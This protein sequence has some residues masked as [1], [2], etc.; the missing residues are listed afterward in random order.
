MPW[1]ETNPMFERRHFTLDL[2][3][4]LWSM[5]E[6]CA[7]LCTLRPRPATYPVEAVTERIID[8]FTHR[9]RST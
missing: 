3:T 9:L 6:W 1:L 5:T 4:G 2:A 7:L 8:K